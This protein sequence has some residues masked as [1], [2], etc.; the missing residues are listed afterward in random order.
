MPRSATRTSGVQPKKLLLDLLPDQGAWS[1]EEYLWLTDPTN[2]LVEF[3]D[4]FVEVLPMPTDHHQAILGFL[5]LVFNGFVTASGGKVRFAPLRLRLRA[6]KFR[7]P[8]L[9]LLLDGKDPRLQERFWTG[10]D[11][12]LEVVSKDHPE[13]DLVQKRHEYAAAQIPE[14]WIVNPLTE[15]IL[16]YPLKGTKYPKAGAYARGSSAVSF[17]L[18][19]FAVNVDAVFDAD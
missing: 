18:P 6:G 5:F 8:D 12:V 1:D 11:L 15:T 4:G 16:V 7:E 2:R 13:R 10:A 9:L 19:K 3:S 17:L 14:Y